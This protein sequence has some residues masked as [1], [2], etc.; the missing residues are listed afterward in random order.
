MPSIGTV[1]RTANGGVKGQ[2]KTLSIR[3]EIEIS[4]N[5]NKSSEVQPDYRVVAGAGDA[6]R[7]DH[8]WR[9]GGGFGYRLGEYIRLGLDVDRFE[10][11]SDVDTRSYE[12]WR[13]GGSVTYGIKQR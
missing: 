3:A 2:L 8:G 5:R 10:R 12:S 4:P 6:A 1:S 9:Y 11:T 13:I 7:R